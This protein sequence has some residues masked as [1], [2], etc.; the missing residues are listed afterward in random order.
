MTVQIGSDIVINDSLFL[1]NIVGAQGR[2]DN[3]ASK[4]H[5]LANGTIDFSNGVIQKMDMAADV[6]F[7]VPG[8]VPDVASILL[9]LDTSTTPHTP[10]FADTGGRSFSWAGGTEPTWS[11]FRFWQVYIQVASSNIVRVSASGFGGIAP[12]PP[13]ETVSLSGTLNTPNNVIGSSD[14]GSGGIVVGWAFYA[15][16]R[17]FETTTEPTAPPTSDR[18]DWCSNNPPDYT[19]YMRITDSTG[20]DVDAVL[21]SPMNTWNQMS[22]S[23]LVKWSVDFQTAEI[24]QVKIEISD[25]SDG[26]NILTT[27]YYGI[28]VESGL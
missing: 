25:A 23:I 1:Q 28:N 2:H 7:S 11:E 9:L 12:P 20:T 13:T 14:G 6:T 18:G 8:T 22:N 3:F 27:G 21:S 17:I 24:G 16:G 10:T 15:D 4:V 19:Y 26:S 5:T